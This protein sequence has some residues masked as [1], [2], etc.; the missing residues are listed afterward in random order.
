MYWIDS[1]VTGEKPRLGVASGVAIRPRLVIRAHT[2]HA[3]IGDFD[4]R[5]GVLV[6]TIPLGHLFL[7]NN[8]RFQ[9][10]LD[11]KIFRTYE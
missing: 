10:K 2:F 3:S 6:A 5:V 4:R 7:S 9:A 8:Y 1:H 11:L